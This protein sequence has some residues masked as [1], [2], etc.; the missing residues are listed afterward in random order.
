MRDSWGIAQADAADAPNDAAIAAE[1][2]DD[3][4]ADRR[5]RCRESEQKVETENELAHPDANAKRARAD[6]AE[7]TRQAARL[8]SFKKPDEISRNPETRSI[9]T[10]SRLV[11]RFEVSRQTADLDDQFS[12]LTRLETEAA[13]PTAEF[14]HDRVFQQLCPPGATSGASARVVE[15]C[16]RIPKQ[17]LKTSKRISRDSKIQRIAETIPESAR[18]QATLRRE[19]DEKFKQNRFSVCPSESTYSL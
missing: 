11:S 10:L 18:V 5:S 7:E 2:V 6:A 9:T 12:V 1:F 17:K 8:C 13:N 3:D 16:I 19:L 4:E 14:S 15:T